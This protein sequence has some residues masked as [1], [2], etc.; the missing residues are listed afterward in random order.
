MPR[1]EL[2]RAG[3]AQAATARRPTHRPGANPRQSA[4]AL[5]AHVPRE[6]AALHQSKSGAFARLEL[7]NVTVRSA[8]DPVRE[9][10]I[11]KPGGVHLSA[12]VRLLECGIRFHCSHMPTTPDSDLPA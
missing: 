11:F 5:P 8:F 7:E 12:R 6:A 10:Q 1:P 2:T 4:R 3:T 9:Q